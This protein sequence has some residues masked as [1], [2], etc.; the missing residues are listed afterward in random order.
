MFAPE[1]SRGDLVVM[2]AQRKIF[3]ITPS[4]DAPELAPLARP[5]HDRVMAMLEEVKDPELPMLSIRDLGIL[6]G[7][8]KTLSN[9]LT[10]VI[11]PT[12][13]GCPAVTAI[14]DAI[15][16]RLDEAGYELVK[17]HEQLSPA[18]TT[19]WMSEQGKRALEA[20]GIA[21]PLP[22]SCSNPVPAFGLTC[23]NCQSEDTSMLSEF[24]STACKAMYRCSDCLETFDYFKGF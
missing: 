5:E 17:I 23:P 13:S 7:L 16:R 20:H 10:V 3:P 9:E 8:G 12:Y 11:T 22:S 6:R 18:W 15:S 14:C 24:G 19:D 21:A 1:S 2:T 4:F